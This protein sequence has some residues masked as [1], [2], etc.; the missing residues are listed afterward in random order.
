M[1]SREE[2]DLE[3]M[4]LASELARQL[5]HDFSNFLYNLFLQIEIGAIAEKSSNQG[6]WQAIK[7]DGDKVSRR[8]QEWARFHDRFLYT[9][10]AIDLHEVLCTV[11]Q[12]LSS[13]RH[14]VQLAPEITAGPLVIVCSAV[15]CKHLLRLLIEDL[16]ETAAESAEATPAVTVQTANVNQNAVVRIAGGVN[17]EPV[18]GTL[19]A[20]ACRSLAVRIGAAIHRERSADGRTVLLV[21]FPLGQS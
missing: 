19:L 20:A 5:C 6:N 9:E 1:K 2:I 8:L 13:Q 10:T 7:Q 3:N 12:E 17:S 11:A 15:D 14:T 18:E 16:F 4:A 21:E